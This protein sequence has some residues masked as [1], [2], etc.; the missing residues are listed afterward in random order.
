MSHTC[1][2][3][4]RGERNTGDLEKA[5]SGTH[6]NGVCVCVLVGKLGVKASVSL[7]DQRQCSCRQCE[8]CSARAAMQTSLCLCTWHALCRLDMNT[9][10]VLLAAKDKA[11]ASAAHAQF[12][13]K[14][15]S[16]AYLALALGV[17]SSRSFTVYG[18][19][20]QHPS[21]KVARQVVQGGQHALTHM[22]VRGGVVECCCCSNAGRLLRACCGLVRLAVKAE[23]VASTYVA[24]WSVFT[25]VGPAACA[26]AV[27]LLYRFAPAVFLSR[28]GVLLRVLFPCCC[29]RCCLPTQM[30]S[31]TLHH[32]QDNRPARN[33]HTAAA[34]LPATTAA[35]Q[36]SL[37]QASL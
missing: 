31:C 1:C 6:W 2:T 26:S 32:L 25:A 12:R 10:G 36:A 30:C 4:E 5:G 33:R 7:A 23:L 22:E 13:A 18:P 11:T 19:I 9:S 20:G 8:S 16:K 15:V 35:A 21:V 34:Q 24:A 37:L 28:T 27:D 3:G 29:R 17:P 14:T